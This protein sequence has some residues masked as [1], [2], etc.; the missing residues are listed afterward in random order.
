MRKVR[1][2]T[3]LIMLIAAVSMG[4]VACADINK[5]EDDGRITL[6]TKQIYLTV[7]EQYVIVA[8]Y[9]DK[10]AK[11]KWSVDK[12]LVAKVDENGVLEVLSVGDA[13]I[14]ATL[15]NG[16]SAQCKLTAADYLVNS[17][18][19]S[20]PDKKRFKTVQEAADLGGNIVVYN[21]V[22]PEYVITD[23]PCKLI[24]VGSVV[25]CGISGTSLDIEGVDFMISDPLPPNNAT[26]T[27]SDTLKMTNCNITVSVNVEKPKELTGGYGIYCGANVQQISITKTIISNY[28]MGIYLFQTSA[29]IDISDVSLNNCK[30]GISVDVK[31]DDKTLENFKAKGKIDGNL[32]NNCY[33]STEFNYFGTGYRGELDF[34]D[35]IGSTNNDQDQDK[36]E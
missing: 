2:I 35:H 6:E 32:F 9:L 22:Y 24:G 11:V 13:I 25:M 28:R 29:T 5:Y 10:G 7:G 27:V 20:Q 23:K 21:G 18:F 8:N 1:I 36:K 12:P 4:L 17:G 14:K 31:G 33:K 16:N 19:E 3:L 15:P 34:K 30:I 26:V